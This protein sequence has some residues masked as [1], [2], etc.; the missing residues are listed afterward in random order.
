MRRFTIGAGLV[1]A[2]TGLFL[3]PPAPLAN[4]DSRVC[5]LLT[6]WAGPGNPSGQVAIVEIDEKSL[7]QFGRWPWPR[8]LLGRS[9]RSIS[10]HGAAAIV[11]AM[12]FPQDD[13]EP[14]SAASSGG[15]PRPAT[16]DEAL[17]D[18]LSRQPA[19]IGYALRFDPRDTPSAGCFLRPLPLAVVGQGFDA[20]RTFARATGVVCSVAPVSQAAAGS[21]FLNA[22][23]DRDGVLRRLP[24][25]AQ[26]GDRFYPSLALA[27]L[28]VYRN[29]SAM[30]LAADLYG[31]VHLRLDGRSVPL[32]GGSAMRL[33]FR[34]PR[35][36]FPR[37][38]MADILSG[39]VRP[40][41]L[42]G[43]IAVVGGSAAGLQQAVVTPVDP[44]FP[45]VEVQATAIDNL[46]Q[47]DSFRR[48]GAARIW[49][50]LIALL[51]G[52]TATLILTR[53][54]SLWGVLIAVAVA[55]AVWTGCALLLTRAGM[56][57]SPLPATSTLAASCCALT[58]LSY[59]DEKRNVERARKQLASAEALT[60][61]VRQESELRYQRL[62]ENVND[63]IIV[64][65][66]VGRLVFAN[67]RFREWF[68]WLDRE[69]REVKLEDYVAPEW[70]AE[71][72]DRHDRRMRGETMPD[73][74]EY[75]GICAG[76]TR[77]WIEARVTI[78]E[79]GGRIAGTQAALRDV[80]ERKRIEAQ[81]LQ[82][83]KMESV[84]RLAGGVAHDLNNLLTI[85]NGYSDLLLS[86][87]WPDDEA[88]ESLEQIRLAGERAADL[89]Q[90]LL[91]FS[92]KQLVRPRPLSPNEVVTGAEKMFGRLIG[93]DIAL[94][95]NLSPDVGTVMADL[96]QLQ[97]VLMNLVV[98]A[99]DG[100]PQGGALTIET[101]NVEIAGS[102]LG[103][104]PEL[105]PGHYVYIGV[106]D[107]GIGMG[108][109][110]KK[111]LFEPFFTTKEQGKG[112]GLGLAT[113]YGIVRQSGGWIG[114]S[115]ELGHGATFHICLPRIV[116][117]AADEAIPAAA[118][119]ASRGRETILV[120]EDQQAVRQFAK[121]VLEGHGYRVLEVSNGPDAIA[122]VEHYPDVIHLL[123]TDIVLPLMSGRV[124]AEKLTA[125]RPAIRV[126]FMS[127]YSEEMLG[128][129]GV[130]A[131]ELP[132]LP[133]PFSPEALAAKVRETLG[134]NGTGSMAGS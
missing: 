131:G 74:F 66:I 119:P 17:A 113:A 80:S 26:Y 98:N 100:M 49:E 101:R 79:D 132:Y 85:I 133:K 10:E 14:P 57:L 121:T 54:R 107:T 68:G 91:A 18:A 71:L 118:V 52:L 15:A 108:E 12:M 35:Q 106:A 25:V 69:I 123:L 46:I 7:A 23:P 27:A 95:L 38:S 60:R 127:G 58:F 32:E 16:N 72:R 84:G 63:A 82:A 115:S 43:R 37:L 21:G 67:R 81:Y 89:T 65:D 111:H 50:A 41:A 110:V 20:G 30:Q 126:I 129:H 73:H 28:S 112:T 39:A 104:D 134:T 8:D 99:R 103:Q 45:D 29:V 105:P 31:A 3:L 19:V 88:R 87:S 130:L 22:A 70:Q 76:G 2:I 62:V 59:L 40:D 125:A 109:D 92:R 36:S 9:V 97:Q 53:A 56:L 44:L 124:L 93:E 5:D 86:E 4:L 117:E 94:T 47:A 33:R 128:N 34:G 64:D 83:Q 78:V 96:G 114:V 42:R 1:V 61:E 13:R 75:E 11:L 116:T 6:G 77:I 51:A 90:K 55:A 102:F 24:L 122:L 48:P 120:V